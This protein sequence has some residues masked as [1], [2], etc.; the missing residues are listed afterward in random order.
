MDLFRLALL[1]SLLAFATVGCRPSGRELANRDPWT[2]LSQPVPSDRFDL[3]FW[4]SQLHARSPLWARA[5]RFCA[6]QADRYPNCHHVVLAQW[7][8]QDPPAPPPASRAAAPGGPS[9]QE[10]PR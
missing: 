1:L 10:R 4:A 5:K 7:W 9:S 8:E 6:G 2:S 3:A